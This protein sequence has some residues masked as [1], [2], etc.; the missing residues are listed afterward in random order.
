MHPWVVEVVVVAIFALACGALVVARRRGRLG[1]AAVGLFVVALAAWV[2]A[3]VAIA[4]EFHGANDFATC[5]E[6]GAVHY[7]A[8]VA[9]IL[10]PLLISLAA[11]AMLVVRGGRWRTRRATAR[12]NHA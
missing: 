9:F 12:E 10:P 11:L 5:T 7:A 1:A 6:C 8:S 4:T 2:A 3:F